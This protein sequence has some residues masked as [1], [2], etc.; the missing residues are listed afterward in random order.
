MKK[1]Y[2]IAFVALSFFALTNSEAFVFAEETQTFDIETS[3]MIED[4]DSLESNSFERAE[5]FKWG[6]VICIKTGDTIELSTDGNNKNLGIANQRPAAFKTAKSIIVKSDIVLPADSKNLFK[7]LDTITSFEING[8]F[9][10]SKVTTFDHTFSNMT[11]VKT[12]D[13]RGFDTSKVTTFS[14]MFAG[15]LRLESLDVSDFET[16]NASYFGYMFQNVKSLKNL[17]VSNFNTGKAGNMTIMFSEMRNLTSLDISNFDTSNVTDMRGMLFGLDRLSSLTIGPQ[18]SNLNLATVQLRAPYTTDSNATGKW[19]ESQHRA[20]YAAQEDAILK[21]FDDKNTIYIPEI[22]NPIQLDMD[23][24]F[25]IDS[26]VAKV[27]DDLTSTITIKPIDNYTYDLAKEI[28]IDLKEFTFSNAGELP[29]TVIV[30]EYDS[31]DVMIGSSIQNIEDIQLNNITNHNYIKILL[32]Q[33]LWNNNIIEPENYIVSLKY[34]NEL[35]KQSIEKKGFFK[36]NSGS[37]GFSSVP[38]ELEFESVPVNMLFYNNIIERTEKDW[39]LNIVD[40]RGTNTDGNANHNIRTNW[41][42]AVTAAPFRDELNTEISTDTLGLVYIKD[43]KRTNIND[44]DEVIIERHNVDGENPKNN[45]N[46]SIQWKSDEGI[47]LIA[48]NSS[49]LKGEIQYST[50]VNFEL[51]QAP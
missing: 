43:S 16:S 37:I 21:V 46:S 50:N 35:G 14:A 49:K 18:T 39:G 42:I 4:S 25:D 44:S 11:N 24:T 20:V 48:Q 15:M 30:E 13:L 5:T 45:A 17:D 22:Q 38:K 27:N 2:I 7:D 12:L 51:R 26:D 10:T 32:T 9:D 36:V 34:T 8:H 47:K 28:L 41:E 1:I 6:D 29:E 31:N 19:M 23:I 3:M 40:Y 33:H